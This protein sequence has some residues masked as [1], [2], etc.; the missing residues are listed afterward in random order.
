MI[1][2]K[3]YFMPETTKKSIKK[4]NNPKKEEHHTM[5]NIPKDPVILLSFINTKL[6]NHYSSLQT[7]CDDLEL[8]IQEVSSKLET[9]N[10][11]YDPARNQFILKV[12]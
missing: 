12:D 5:S 11:R 3:G 1:S 10:Y 6:R 9:M 4:Y 8:D 2:G 7:L